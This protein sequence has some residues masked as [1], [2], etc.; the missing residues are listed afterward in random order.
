MQG[1]IIKSGAAPKDEFL[2]LLSSAVQIGMRKPL[3]PTAD[4]LAVAAVQAA[5]SQGK[6]LLQE[7]GRTYLSEPCNVGAVDNG[8]FTVEPLG[9][10]ITY[11]AYLYSDGRASGTKIAAPT[12]RIHRSVP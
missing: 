8:V 9:K 6:C 10:R 11:F 5:T 2:V 12:M 4:M 1:K 7:N 3:F